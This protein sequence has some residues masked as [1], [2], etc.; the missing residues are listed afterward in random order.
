MSYGISI[1][2]DDL[3][4]VNL[5]MAGIKNGYPK[6]VS[7]AIN[8][9]LTGVRTDAVNVIYSQLNLTKTRIRKDFSIKKSNWSV[10]EGRISASGKGVNLVEFGARQL[11]R[12][13]VSVKIKRTG[14]RE[15]FG[16]M[17]IATAKGN[18]LVFERSEK[19][20]MGRAPVPGRAYAK[21]PRAMRLPIHAKPG[22]AIEDYFGDERAMKPVLEKAKDRMDK[23]L[24]ESLDFELS[25][26]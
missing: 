24:G 6:V 3:N 20:Y 13:G 2:K 21:L 5:M 17:F 12:G 4:K 26:L 25:K 9:T 18:R 10:L 23:A 19:I 11:K 14:A 15:K 16:H 1:N 7:R 8:K 22:P